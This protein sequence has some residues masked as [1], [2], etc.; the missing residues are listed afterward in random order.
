[1][2]SVHTNSTL[3][4]THNT[5]HRTHYR[6]HGALI[7]L[8]LTTVCQCYDNLDIVMLSRNILQNVQLCIQTGIVHLCSTLQWRI[9]RCNKITEPFN[10]EPPN[11][12]KR[13][14]YVYGFFQH[15]WKMHFLSFQDFW[16][17]FFTMWL[18]LLKTF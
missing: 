15:S 16:H 18:F 17:G 4:N 10:A 2:H 6:E 12:L 7:I 3:Y 9:V 1:M 14:Q 8:H 13:K 5:L 11:T